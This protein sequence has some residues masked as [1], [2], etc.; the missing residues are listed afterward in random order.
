M[1]PTP[2]TVEKST[3]LH[4]DEL[5]G[6]TALEDRSLIAAIAGR[7]F[8]SIS[9][10]TRLRSHGV[11]GRQTTGTNI[12]TESGGDLT[13]KAK[14]SPSLSVDVTTGRGLVSGNQATNAGVWAA[15]N[16]TVKTFTGISS[17]HAT[18]ARI[19]RVVLTVRSNEFPAHTGDDTILQYLEGTPAG[20]PTAPAIPAD[21]ISLATINV[22]ALASTITAGMIVNAA[23]TAGLFTG[24]MP[25]ADFTDADSVSG[26]R[27]GDLFVEPTGVMWVY[28]KSGVLVPATRIGA[29]F[30]RNASFQT[31]NTTTAALSWDNV[32][33][34]ISTQPDSWWWDVGTPA[35]MKCRWPGYYDISGALLHNQG[36]F[37][38]DWRLKLCFLGDTTNP[39]DHSY[40][41]QRYRTITTIG[42]KCAAAEWFNVVITSPGNWG[43]AS[44]ASKQVRMTY[45]GPYSP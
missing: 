9:S 22:P 13:V 7:A 19:D 45:N 27:S 43:F 33:P 20:S 2:I 11:L 17:G 10:T 26:K 21:S 41:N 28:V 18:N 16:Q 44:A 4:L 14:S 42:R 25:V 31:I 36:E 1:A 34:D 38:G 5:P 40:N 3:W 39:V 23:P 37:A 6:Y 12:V 32:D 35:V 29:T 30:E 15:Q 8:G 24:V